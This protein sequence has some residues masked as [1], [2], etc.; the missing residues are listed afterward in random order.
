MILLYGYVLSGT[1][2]I[3]YSAIDNKIHRI[4]GLSEQELFYY[5]IKNKY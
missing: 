1:F 3:D 2:E 4:V 5:L